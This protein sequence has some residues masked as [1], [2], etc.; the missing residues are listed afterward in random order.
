[1]AFPAC[2]VFIYGKDV[3]Q[4]IM[5]VKI[6][7]AGGSSER[8]AGTVT[9]TLANFMDKYTYTRNDIIT[10]SEVKGK[11][12]NTWETGKA[13][14][15]FQNALL[16]IGLEA[17]CLTVSSKDTPYPLGGDIPVM[18]STTVQEMSRKLAQATDE[19]M[20]YIWRAFSKK[21]S[22]TLEDAKALTEKLNRARKGMTDDLIR[23]ATFSSYREEDLHF[24]I[25]QQVVHD[26]LSYTAPLTPSGRFSKKLNYHEGLLW[27]YPMQEGDCIFNLN[28]PVRIALRDPFDPRVWYWAF[29]GFIDIWTEDSGVNGESEL[30]ITCTDVSKMV[31]YSIFQFKTG[32]LDLATESAFS[33][34]KDA[35]WEL[36]SNTSFQLQNELYEGM[37]LLEILELTFFGSG[38]ASNVVKQVDIQDYKSLAPVLSE[39]ELLDLFRNT[40]KLSPQQAQEAIAPF[41]SFKGED[42]SVQFNTTDNKFLNNAKA[43]ELCSTIAGNRKAKNAERF[44]S[45]DWSGISTARGV[46]FKRSSDNVGIRFI[47]FG[48]TDS[49]DAKFMYA[50][51]KSLFYWNEM[52]HHRVRSSDLATMRKGSETDSSSSS[53]TIENIIYKIGTDLTNYPVGHGYVYA[54]LPGS[55]EKVFGDKAVDQ[56]LGG[57]GSLHSSFKDRLSILYDF[58]E[59]LDFR[60]YASPKGDVIFEIPFYDFE[61]FEF[62]QDSTKTTGA[63]SKTSEIPDYEDLFTKAYTGKYS[64][65]ELADLT[66]LSMY[67][68]ETP[69]G[70]DNMSNL[71]DYMTHPKFDYGSHF[72]VDTHEQS[73]FSN[74]CNDRG[75][76]TAYRCLC[77]YIQSNSGYQNDEFRSYKSAVDYALMPSLGFRIE[78]GNMFNFINGSYAAE[79]YSA[80]QLNKINANARNVGLT[81]VPKFGLMVNRPLYWI[82]RTYYGNIVSVSHTYTWN[83]DVYTSIN[84]NQIKAWSGEEDKTTKRPKMKHFGNSDRP[85]NLYSFLKASLANM[86]GRNKKGGAE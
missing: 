17:S 69:G 1:M 56:G 50:S 14:D 35:K 42:G 73:G 15:L 20:R 28:D 79:L 58:A 32:G 47:A 22:I 40:L 61:P 18:D 12:S 68:L 13:Q 70:L 85:F 46:T 8:S 54:F 43:Q 38:S 26:K 31:R 27:D 62:V 24:N 2:R 7:Q 16:G 11:I 76:I 6:N 57:V 78:E 71:S 19:E 36:A 55:M 53:D 65:E 80:L 37:T 63:A 39:Q 84:M 64:S 67:V 52:M 83:G 34:V 23:S 41:T 45:L 77:N 51:T 3:S 25:K 21:S 9:F 66:T 44:S 60:F 74:T 30:T 86:E 4:D 82:P 33:Y 81:T 29:T 10:I 5:S 59:S 49:Y 72:S 48:E 75:L